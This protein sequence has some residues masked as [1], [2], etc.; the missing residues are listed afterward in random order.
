V[1]FQVCSNHGPQGLDG[2][3]IAKTNFTYVS[4]ENRNLQNKQANIS[5][6]LSTEY[7]WVKEIQNC[8]NTSKEPSPLQRRY[9]YKNAKFEWIH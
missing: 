2:A 1:N 4:I 5:I 3:T 7:S 8:S 6:K 9:N